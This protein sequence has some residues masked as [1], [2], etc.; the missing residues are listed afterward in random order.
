MNN[1]IYFDHSATTPVLP[2]VVEEMNKCLTESW[3][4][5]NSLHQSGQQARGV[6]EAARASVAADLGAEPKEIIFTG[7]GSEA[8]NLAI[9]GLYNA[10]RREGNHVV[11][12]ALEHPAVLETCRNLEESGAN[13]TYLYPDK[14]GILQPEQVEAAITEKTILI[15][16]MMANNIIGTVQPIK[17]IAAIAKKHKV[18]FH[19]DA[20][21]AAGTLPID[22]NDLGVDLLAISAHKFHGPKGVGALYIRKGVTIK[23][24][25]HGGG[26][27]RRL[28]SGTENVPGI[29]GLAKALNISTRELKIKAERMIKL[30]DR[31]AAGVLSKIDDVALVGHQDQ[32]LPGNACFIFKY[33]EGESL[34]LQLDMVGIAASSGSACSSKSLE[35]SHALLGIGIAPAQA[36]GSLR[37]TL[38]RSTTADEVD[39]FLEQLPP[40]VARLRKMSPFSADREAEYLMNAGEHNQAHNR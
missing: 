27:E 2:E 4:N 31:L 38:G 10:R 37:I 16:V 13:I 17:D 34:V 25:I 40:I 14:S 19:T 36:H 18:A 23:P 24:I 20:V 30:R 33:I 5:P 32:R 21:Q 26:Q 3:G 8:D 7:C 22:V 6:V 11:C 29:A 15:T 12:F 9:S 39:Y 35:P 28:R 1:K